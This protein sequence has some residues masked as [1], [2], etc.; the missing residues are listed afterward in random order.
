[1]IL[2]FTFWIASNFHNGSK[3]SGVSRDEHYQV[4]MTQKGVEF[5]W[6]I[7]EMMK[8][9]YKSVFLVLYFCP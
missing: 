5:S 1:M 8:S 6:I 9:I 2:T 4:L 3:A 7:L